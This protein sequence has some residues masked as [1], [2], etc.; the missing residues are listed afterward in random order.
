MPVKGSFTGKEE[1]RRILP[2]GGIK[3]SMV[4]L[5]SIKKVV[6]IM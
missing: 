3:L 4:G 6:K 2:R 1:M 5:V